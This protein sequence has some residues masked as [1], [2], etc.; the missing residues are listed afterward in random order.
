MN[1]AKRRRLNEAN[2]LLLRTLN[3]IENIKDDEE[4]T[5]YNMPENLQGSERGYNMENNVDVLEE[6]IDYLNDALY[7]MEQVV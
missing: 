7:N 2:I 4:T 5:F 3:I 6:A 1:K